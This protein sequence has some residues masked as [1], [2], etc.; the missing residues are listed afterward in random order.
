M[1]G[2]GPFAYPMPVDMGGSMQ[3]HM[4]QHN[5]WD[6]SAF[7]P[8]MMGGPGGMMTGGYDPMMGLMGGAFPGMMQPQSFL[9]QANPFDLP[10]RFS[11]AQ[12]VQTPE[13][14]YV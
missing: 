12:P 2:G 7:N 1:S 10:I 3:Q 8:M 14:G 13:G 4:P 9:Q 5:S 11:F 6:P